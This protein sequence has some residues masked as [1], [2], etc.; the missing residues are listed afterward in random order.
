VREVDDGSAELLDGDE[1]LA[2]ARACP[3]AWPMWPGRPDVRARV[4]RRY[5]YRA[6]AQG[7][8]PVRM[9]VANA[10]LFKSLL[11]R[12]IGA[13]PAGAALLHTTTAPTMLKGSPKEN[14]LPQD[15]TGWINYALRPA[16]PRPR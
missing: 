1:V 2:E 3:E 12:Q 7:P 8:F 16:T 14:V 4:V 5:P 15:A 9:A 11:I 13:S 10:W 6:C